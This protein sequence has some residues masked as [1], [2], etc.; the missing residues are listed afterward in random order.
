M[1]PLPCSL[2]RLAPEGMP[3][4]KTNNVLGSRN[5][6]AHVLMQRLLSAVWK[7]GA[8]NA[9]SGLVSFQLEAEAVPEVSEKYEISSV[10]TFLF[11]KVS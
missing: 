4:G 8:P 7:G 2:A 9:C 5:T 11:F 10:P 1:A 3:S 6:T